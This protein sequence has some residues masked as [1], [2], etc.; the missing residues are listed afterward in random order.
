MP[1]T[2]LHIY[3]STFTNETRILKE[4]SAIARGEL[5]DDIEIIAIGGENLP[6]REQLDE[7]RWVWRVPVIASRLGRNLVAKVIRHAEWM[8]RILLG[9]LGRSVECVNCHSLSVLPLAVVIKLF[10]RTRLIYDTHEL[11]TESASV[12]GIRK[13]VAKVVERC[14]IRFCDNVI[15]VGD[16]IAEWYRD[17]YGLSNVSVVRNKPIL[18]TTHQP[19]ER[20]LLKEALNLEPS[21]RL[22]LYQGILERGR[23]LEIL[24]DAFEHHGSQNHFVAMGY[25]SWEPLIRERAERCSNIHFHPAVSPQELGKYTVCADVGLC[26]IEDCCLSYR[27]CLPNKLFE[28]LAAGLPTLISNLPDMVR[29]IEGSGCGWIV[30]PN[31]GSVSAVVNGITPE[32]L[33]EK[34]QAARN[35]RQEFTWEEEERTLIAVYSKD[36]PTQSAQPRRAG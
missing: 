2:N 24:L 20:N 15:V 28:Y 11:E 27:Y 35:H 13:R 19:D 26:L 25:G 22:F 32:V 10:W 16:S 33:A 5:F 9:L 36:F 3:P 12:S 31:S 8:L 14:L 30:E 23:G 4:T 17:A 7:R 18:T 29:V 6:T 1:R 34:A 21:D